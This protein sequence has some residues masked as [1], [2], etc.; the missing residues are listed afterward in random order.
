MLFVVL[1][2]TVWKPYCDSEFTTG[3]SLS[4]DVTSLSI[5]SYWSFC[6]KIYCTSSAS[7]RDFLWL[8]LQNIV[9]YVT[10]RWVTSYRSF[11]CYFV[12]FSQGD[13]RDAVSKHYQLAAHNTL[14]TCSFHSSPPNLTVETS[15]TTEQFPL[16][17]HFCN[18]LPWS[19]WPSYL[20]SV[21]LHCVKNMA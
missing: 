4:C 10:V 12:S 14:S 16:T 1:S 6:F 11:R 15:L 5:T 7:L 3:N 17:A 9:C 18:A 19:Y 8:C 20:I 21:A 2:A 13:C